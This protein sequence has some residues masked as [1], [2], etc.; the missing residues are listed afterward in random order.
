MSAS[1]TAGLITY[2]PIARTM[3]DRIM[4]C[5]TIIINYDIVSGK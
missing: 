1:C 2:C 5:D 3:D 4:R